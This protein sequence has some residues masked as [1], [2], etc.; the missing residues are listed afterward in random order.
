MGSILGAA[1]AT[2]LLKYFT[3][4]HL[5]YWGIPL[6]EV[7]GR[8]RGDHECRGFLPGPPPALADRLA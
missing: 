4:F 5:P 1:R 6:G 7:I 8:F 2:N 3:C